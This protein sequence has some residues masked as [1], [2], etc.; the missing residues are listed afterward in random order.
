[1]ELKP[2]GAKR[3]ILADELE[4]AEVSA[5]ANASESDVQGE[6]DVLQNL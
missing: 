5:R 1:M 6:G 4:A 2:R 3:D